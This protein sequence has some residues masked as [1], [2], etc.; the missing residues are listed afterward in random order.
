MHNGNKNE[1]SYTLIYTQQVH[2]KKNVRKREKE[3]K[4]SNNLNYLLFIC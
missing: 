3:R 1:N 2:Y 4:P